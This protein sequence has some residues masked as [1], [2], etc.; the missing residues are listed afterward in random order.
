MINKTRFKGASLESNNKLYTKIVK[1][2]NCNIKIVVETNNPN[3]DS[4]VDQL[5]LEAWKILLKGV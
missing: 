4:I 1:H 5:A 3:G 2:Q